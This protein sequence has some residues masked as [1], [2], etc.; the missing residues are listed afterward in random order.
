MI[1]FAQFCPE[2]VIYIAPIPLSSIKSFIYRQNMRCHHGS[3]FVI[4]NSSKQS[5]YS[6]NRACYADKY[7]IHSKLGYPNI[8]KKSK[9]CGYAHRTCSCTQYEPVVIIFYLPRWWFCPGK[10]RHWSSQRDQSPRHRQCW[11][12]YV[13]DE[14]K[15]SKELVVFPR[16]M[17]SG[18][19]T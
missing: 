11:R 3:M 9:Y 5:G 14:L 2:R 17:Y 1:S 15:N 10:Q 6:V 13:P 12:T 8:W 4:K 18:W 19:S 7:G 16:D